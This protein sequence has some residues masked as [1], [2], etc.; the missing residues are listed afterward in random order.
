MRKLDRRE[1]R[2]RAKD[3]V[4]RARGRIYNENRFPEGGRKI[5]YLNPP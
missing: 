2:D 4:S 5:F 1:L 3:L